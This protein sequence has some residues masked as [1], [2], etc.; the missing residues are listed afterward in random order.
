[1]H[2]LVERRIIAARRRLP[3]I[4]PKPTVQVKLT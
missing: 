2:L 3:L 4:F 1:M